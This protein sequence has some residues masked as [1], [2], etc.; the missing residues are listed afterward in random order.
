MIR[1][2]PEY[3]LWGFAPEHFFFRCDPA[4]T[5][6]ADPYTILS[7]PRAG[8]VPARLLLIRRMVK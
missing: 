7:T 3:A 4:H 2:T 1:E 6:I 8:A 5:D